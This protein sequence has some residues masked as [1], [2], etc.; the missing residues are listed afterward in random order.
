MKATV[1]AVTKD[2]EITEELGYIEENKTF[3]GKMAGICYQKNK[4]FDTYVSDPEK[5]SNRFGVVANTGHHS[6][7]DHSYITIL[8]ED[9]SK[10][11]AMV[12][13]SCNMYNT[14]EKSGRYTVMTGN[15]KEEQD[16]YEKWKTIF[17][18]RVLELY[19]D[20]DDATSWKIAQENARYVLSVFTRSTTMSYTTSLRQWNYIYDWCQ[21]AIKRCESRTENF[22]KELASDLTFLFKT[23]K[24]YLYVAE[25]RDNK[26]R[27][28]HFLVDLYS[29]VNPLTFYEEV[30]NNYGFS[31]STSYSSSFV[32]LA[33]A[34]RHRTVEYY[35]IFSPVYNR[36]FYVPVMISDVKEL[37]DEWVRGLD[38]LAETN[39]PQ[40]TL[41]GVIEAGTLENFK[42]K[43][44]ER[45][46][47]RVQIEVMRQTVN[48]IEAFKEH[49]DDLSKMCRMYVDELISDSKISTKCTL[50]GNCKE[51]C[52]WGSAGALNR[53]I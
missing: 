30:D 20:Y 40:A 45:L 7:A 8:F 41:V 21:D 27:Y 29:D 11:L 13:N 37:S 12:L 18:D 4:Y 48:T 5:A 17:H 22:Y 3:S 32:A 50:L 10:M 15:S 6:I 49:Y 31:Y 23:I 52:Y 24:E 44:E 51:P 26:H 36:N 19:P 14:S 1:L 16:L 2:L 46:C 28:F 47:G 42:L 9:I 35:M 38:S 39:Y 33:Q 53:L 34:Q 43:C 25:L